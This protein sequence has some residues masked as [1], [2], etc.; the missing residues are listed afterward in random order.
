M[1][2]GKKRI[3][4][5]KEESIQGRMIK[6]M[7]GKT[8]WYKNNKKKGYD[9]MKVTNN[10]K[11]GNKGKPAPHSRGNK[12]MK[13]RAVLFVEQTP[14]G[15]LARR[16]KELLT[17][18]EPTLGFK[19]RVVERTGRSL[20]SHLSGAGKN[21]EC[22]RSQCV[23]CNQGGE[24]KPN[25]TRSSVVYESICSLCNPG[26]LK[27]GELEQTNNAPSLYVGE[28]SRSVQ[29]RAMEHWGAARRSDDTSH[30][31]RHQKIC[32]FNA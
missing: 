26:A 6:R 25:C 2:N 17:R 32:S 3:H 30:M 9:G 4:L 12:E 14:Q 10:M 19:L 7:T 16:M 11:G 15:E 5:T 8:T 21:K 22:G 27:K 13:T 28:S 20:I 31:I 18:L 24:E 23:T 29:E 1:K